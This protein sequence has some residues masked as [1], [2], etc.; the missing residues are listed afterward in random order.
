M[1]KGLGGGARAQIFC[2][3]ILSGS[4]E[5]DLIK[6]RAIMRAERYLSLRLELQVSA[7]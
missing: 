3:V 2:G 1:V 6:F 4:M 5:E 7:A